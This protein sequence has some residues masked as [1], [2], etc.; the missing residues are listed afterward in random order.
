MD[1]KELI[2]DDMFNDIMRMSNALQILKNKLKKIKENV[3]IQ[4]SNQTSKQT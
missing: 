3:E 4:T 1:K 2:F